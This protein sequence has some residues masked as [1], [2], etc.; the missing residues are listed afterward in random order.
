MNNFCWGELHMFTNNIT[1]V[2]IHSDDEE[3]VRK[4]REIWD[5]ITELIGIN[6][7][8]DFVVTTLYDDDEDEF[9]LLKIQALLEIN[10]EMILY[11]FFIMSLMNS[12]KHH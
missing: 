1:L 11:L 2:P 3:L 5:K 12:L 6:N 9:I 8:T 4:C 7:P 10:I